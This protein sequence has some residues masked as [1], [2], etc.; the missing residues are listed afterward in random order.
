MILGNQPGHM[1]E[2]G[3]VLIFFHWI[4]TANRF[5]YWLLASIQV[6]PIKDRVRNIF[7]VNLM[8]I[9]FH[10]IAQKPSGSTMARMIM[11][12]LPGQ[13]QANENCFLAR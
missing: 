13:I 1:V 10:H 8:G 11:L 9:N 12:L 7:L 3:S 6:V 4:I 5:G 2:Y